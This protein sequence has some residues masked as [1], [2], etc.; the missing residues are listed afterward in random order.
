MN[1][2]WPPA[3]R[4]RHRVT[5]SVRR[6]HHVID[7]AT[8]ANQLSRRFP[9]ESIDPFFPTQVGCESRS[10]KYPYDPVRAKQ[11][12]WK[13]V[14]PNASITELVTLQT[15]RDQRLDAELSGELASSALHIARI[16]AAIQKGKKVE[17]AL[18]WRQLWQQLVNDS[19]HSWPSVSR[20]LERLAR[21]AEV[22]NLPLQKRTSVDPE[23]LPQL[24]L[25]RP[26]ASRTERAESF[27][28]SPGPLCSALEIAAD[29][30]R[31]RDD[32]PA[33]LSVNWK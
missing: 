20:R 32:L 16:G 23:I 21:D 11:L 13:T 4:R 28:C 24:P 1:H 30:P 18:Y 7:R 19:S 17:A 33:S 12:L 31:L 10:V 26:F 9:C 25:A 15:T 6:G 3:A 5:S 14:Y 29:F 2:R 27:R 22:Q 8:S